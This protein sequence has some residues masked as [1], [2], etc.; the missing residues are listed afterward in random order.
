MNKKISESFEKTRIAGSIAADTLDEVS[1][2]IRPGV[3]T[4]QIKLT[5]T[6]GYN[7][8][9]IITMESSMLKHSPRLFII[10]YLQNLFF[11]GRKPNE[12]VGVRVFEEEEEKEEDTCA[13]KISH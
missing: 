7:N 13:L 3:T 4:D 12:D 11:N 9:P 5:S 2:F 10:F 6:Q 1:K 8:L